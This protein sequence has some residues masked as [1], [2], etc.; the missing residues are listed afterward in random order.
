MEELKC[1]LKLHKFDIDCELAEVYW[2]TAHYSA[3]NPDGCGQ[4]AAEARSEGLLAG[5]GSRW[6]VLLLQPAAQDVRW[7]DGGLREAATGSETAGCAKR[8]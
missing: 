8:P 1:F 2:R 5:A 4:P 3:G 6:P 7:G